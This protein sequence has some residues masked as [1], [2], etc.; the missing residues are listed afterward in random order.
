MRKSTASSR[1]FH[2]GATVT[3]VKK[4]WFRPTLLAV[5]L[6]VGLLVLAKGRTIAPFVYNLF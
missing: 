5:G 1:N 4:W 6:F 3:V 2:K